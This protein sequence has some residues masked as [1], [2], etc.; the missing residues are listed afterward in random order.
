MTMRYLLPLLEVAVKQPVWSV[1]ILP[2]T[3]MEFKNAILVRTRG[4]GWGTDGVVVYGVLL[5]M[6]GVVMDLR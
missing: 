6:E 5:S 1:E 3:L 2:V 4:S